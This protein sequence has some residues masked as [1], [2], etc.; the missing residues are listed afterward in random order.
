MTEL[1]VHCEKLGPL[2]ANNYLIYDKASKEAALI[3]CSDVCLEFLS[4]IEE[5]ELN[6]KFILLTHGHFDHVMGVNDLKEVLE[7]S[8][9]VLI[10]END[11]DLLEKINFYTKM[12][13]LE[14]ELIP[15]YDGTIK[16]G[17]TLF[18][19]DC[20]IKVLH[21]AGHTRGSVCYLVGDNLF[22]G[23]T[24]FLGTVGRCDLEG[25]SFKDIEKNIKTKIY[26]LDE[27]TK[28]FTGHGNL[29][30]VKHEMKYNDSVRQT[31]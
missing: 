12:V 13:N 24:I 3:D 11:V 25:G 17:D 21:T 16:D 28:I 7:P 6:L 4:I 15:Q 19:G 18:L 9:Q 14:P 22:S 26:T 8:P 29:T 31:L 30:T 2:E 27:D 23:D 20:E 5:Q 1:F 10:H